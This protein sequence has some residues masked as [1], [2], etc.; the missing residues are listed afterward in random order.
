M[1]I[2]T[3]TKPLQKTKTLSLPTRRASNLKPVRLK[4]WYP[5]PQRQLPQKGLLPSLIQWQGTRRGC[6]P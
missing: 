6:N 3:S 1:R 2:R 4:E 5:D